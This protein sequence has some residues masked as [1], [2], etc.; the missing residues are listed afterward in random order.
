MADNL[1]PYQT[2]SIEKGAAAGKKQSQESKAATIS[3]ETTGQRVSLRERLAELKEST[4]DKK[5][6][7]EKMKEK[8][9]KEE[10]L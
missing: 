8:K 2:E 6:I 7:S 4:V 5:T 1:P 3:G 9:D 10:M